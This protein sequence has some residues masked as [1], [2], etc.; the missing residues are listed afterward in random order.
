MV[1]LKMAFA[2]MSTVS[3]LTACGLMAPYLPTDPRPAAQR[4][5]EYT[6]AMAALAGDYRVI[7]SRGKDLSLIHI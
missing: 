7:D 4:K 6:Q 1:N 3:L 5:V 2:V